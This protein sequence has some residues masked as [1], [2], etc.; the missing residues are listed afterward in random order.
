MSSRLILDLGRP[1]PRH[2]SRSPRGAEP[3][4]SGSPAAGGESRERGVGGRPNYCTPPYAAQ[5]GTLHV[6]ANLALCLSREQVSSA[7]VG[8]RGALAMRL[9]FS[10]SSGYGGSSPHE[11]FHSSSPQSPP[12]GG[13]NMFR[14]ITPAP[15]FSAASCI[16]RVLSLTSPPFLAVGLAPGGQRDH[17][18]VEPL[19]ALAERVLVALLRAGDEPVQ[20]D[21]DMT[22]EPAQ[23]PSSVPVLKLPGT[24]PCARPVAPRAGASAS[25]RAGRSYTS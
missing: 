8:S 22:P 20:R 21:R 1:E 18:V 14:P 12:A 25:G 24:R 15:M 19:A 11:P 7:P 13:P 6:S 10:S 4:G 9:R 2:R 17:P 23:R 16:T 3:C 5:A